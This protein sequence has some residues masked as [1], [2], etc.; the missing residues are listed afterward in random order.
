MIHNQKRIL[1][2]TKLLEMLKLLIGNFWLFWSTY[3][4]ASFT[5]LSEPISVPS[6]AATP[7]VS[8]YAVV[9]R[10]LVILAVRIGCATFGIAS[11]SPKIESVHCFLTACW[12]FVDTSLY[13]YVNYHL[14][15]I[16]F[17]L[18]I[19]PFPNC[20]P[21]FQFQYILLTWK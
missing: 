16:C 20:M 11:L 17:V 2:L 21:S 3:V 19:I 13:D 10:S 18:L 5:V 12:P 1:L 4:A 9:K 6:I 15:S 7:I 8:V 14:I